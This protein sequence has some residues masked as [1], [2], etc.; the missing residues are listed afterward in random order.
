[1]EKQ[2]D[3]PLGI[4]PL[5]Q[6]LESDDLPQSSPPNT[7]I[8]QKP[9]EKIENPSLSPETKMSLP[10]GLPGYVLMSTTELN[11]FFSRELKCKFCDRGFCSISA[12]KKV[13]VTYGFVVTC[14]VCFKSS[15]CAVSLG[16]SRA[17]LGVLLKGGLPDGSPIAEHLQWEA[18]DEEK[19][20]TKRNG[21]K[22]TPQA[23]KRKREL[24]ERRKVVKGSYKSGV[25]LGGEKGGKRRRKRRGIPPKCQKFTIVPTV[26]NQA[27]TLEN[28]HFHKRNKFP[29]SHFVL[30]I[31]LGPSCL[32]TN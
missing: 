5:L 10:P 30:F 4:S 28:A 16:H 12:F 29:S 20:K 6:P 15:S 19:E 8:D 3:L 7:Q 31:F 27:T 21:K 22:K 25:E 13:I 11:N 14:Q 2:R 24:K 18:E 9:Q 26:N 17:L 32:P 1:M 23:K